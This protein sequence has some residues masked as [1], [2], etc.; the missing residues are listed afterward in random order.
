MKV[1][2]EGS[3]CL[4]ELRAGFAER[5]N[6]VKREGDKTHPLGTLC[7]VKREVNTHPNNK[8]LSLLYPYLLNVVFAE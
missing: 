6:K 3:V 4:C 7:R 5:V 1:F 8:L 2:A